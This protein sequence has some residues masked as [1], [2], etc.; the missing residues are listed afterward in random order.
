[1]SMFDVARRPALGDINKKLMELH[2]A[3][4]NE[5]TGKAVL[6][7]TILSLSNDRRSTYIIETLK[8]AEL[9]KVPLLKSPVWKIRV[10]EAGY[11]LAS[12]AKQMLATVSR[13]TGGGI[14][15]QTL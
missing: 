11:R 8:L 5:D 13:E 6:I 1:L 2:E 9:N 10:L 15:M 12:E 3:V 4:K 7:L 14:R